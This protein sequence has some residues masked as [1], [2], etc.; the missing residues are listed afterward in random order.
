MG[1]VKAQ[2]NQG[3]GTALMTKAVEDCKQD[4]F[5]SM[6]LEV[7]ESNEAAIRV[8]EK[9]GFTTRRRLVGYERLSQSQPDTGIEITEIDPYQ[10]AMQVAIHADPDL[11]W[12]CSPEFYAA[13]PPHLSKAYTLE[14]KAF[15]LVMRPVTGSHNSG[16]LLR[17]RNAQSTYWD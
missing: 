5:K 4:G 2:R 13:F 16:C 15:A 14:N 7:F 12:M 10:F 3:L 8:Y 9:C 17:K 6:I 1:I 11:P